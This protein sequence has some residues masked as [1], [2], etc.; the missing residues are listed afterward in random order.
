M[1]VLAYY[2]IATTGR[3]LLDDAQRVHDARAVEAVEL[4]RPDAG[5]GELGR[6]AFLGVGLHPTRRAGVVG[7]GR[8]HQGSHRVRV[9]GQAAGRVGVLDTVGADREGGDTGGVRGG[10]RGALQVLVEAALA[11]VVA[12]LLHAQRR[13]G[14][15]DVEVGV[16]VAELLHHVGRRGGQ[17]LVLVGAV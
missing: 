5:G 10:H 7:R 12:G 11:R 17:D 6:P 2:G 3:G 1:D 15:G 14:R 9:H 16:D 8:G 4:R 13:T